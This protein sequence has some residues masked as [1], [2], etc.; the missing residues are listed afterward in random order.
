MQSGAEQVR[1]PPGREGGSLACEE[2]PVRPRIR[3][4]LV[5]PVATLVL[6]VALAW[7]A[8]RLP[9]GAEGDRTQVGSV[10]KR[11][12]LRAPAVVVRAP[13]PRNAVFVLDGESI[14]QLDPDNESWDETT[15]ALSDDPRRVLVLTIQHEEWRSGLWG[16]TRS[17]RRAIILEQGGSAF[18][19]SQ[20]EEARRRYVESLASNLPAWPSLGPTL[21]S[22]N[23]YEVVRPL[24]PG[25][26]HNL[27]TVLLLAALIYS[28]QWIRHTRAW[29]RQ[30][31]L[32]RGRCP[33]CGY[34]IAGL[35]DPKCPECGASLTP[36]AGPPAAPQ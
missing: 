24:L 10:I 21:V 3:R 29:L 6:L 20:R 7:D 15:R 28:A 32:T 5:N 17:N 12:I 16:L 8:S 26:V 33:R 25:Y 1:R 13:P 31:A 30:R 35:P 9:A 36:E 2:L 34:S 22:G 23:M 18:T 4:L 27:G 11:T 14:R 19:T